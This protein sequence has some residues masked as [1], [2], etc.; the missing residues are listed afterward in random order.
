ML[1][2]ARSLK[3]SVVSDLF[4]ALGYTG[5]CELFSMYLCLFGDLGMDYFTDDF[6]HEHRDGLRQHRRQYY[7]DHGQYPHPVIL[8]RTY[9][10][11]LKGGSA[12]S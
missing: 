6:L 8:V 11:S 9:A 7:L 3:C 5:P 1:R 12:F 2:L 4:K 10:E